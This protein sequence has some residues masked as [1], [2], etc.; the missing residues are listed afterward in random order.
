MVSQKGLNPVLGD[1]P[2]YSFVPPAMYALSDKIGSTVSTSSKAY[3][4]QTYGSSCLS[5]PSCDCLLDQLFCFFGTQRTGTNDRSI[6]PVWPVYWPKKHPRPKA[7]RRIRHC[8]G[9][10][11]CQNNSIFGEFS[12][13]IVHKGA[14]A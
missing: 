1:D 5:R 7:I 14:V 4:R 10:F 3:N 6:E 11:K 2:W 8:L 9:I 13:P 12:Q